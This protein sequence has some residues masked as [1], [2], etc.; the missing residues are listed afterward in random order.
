MTQALRRHPYPYRS[1]LAICSDLDETPDR[2]VYREIVLFLNSTRAT[3]MG[4]GVGLEVGNTLYFD[5]PGDQFAYW[6]TD[7]EGREMSVALMRSGHIDCFHSFGDLATTRSHA[8]RALEEL[9]RRDCQIRVWVDHGTAI[10]NFGADIM[11]GEGDVPGADVYHADLTL[12]HGVRHVWLGRVTSIVGQDVPRRWRGV[13]GTDHAVPSAVTLAKEAA[14]VALG[15]LGHS[16]FAMHWPNDLTRQITLRD[17]QSATEFIRCN[18]HWG[19]VS[20]CDTGEGIAD[21]LTDRYLDALRDGGGS[22]ILY[23]HLGKIRDSRRPF[24]PQTVAAFQRL[25]ERAGRGE[26]LVCTTARMLEYQRMKANVD[27]QVT[28][29][30]SGCRVDVHRRM[31]DLDLS[32]LTIYTPDAP[33]QVRVD[34]EAAPQF[35]VN[36][37]E[38]GRTS[39]SFA[40]KPLHLPEI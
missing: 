28:P 36:P 40:W 9:S 12:S 25:A 19:G 6:N 15:G 7:D 5:M 16:K 38:D 20:S 22:S 8:G 30:P 31:P 17:G 11:Q 32:G 33:A 37:P 27:V 26:V 39:I 29:D 21:V 18:P 1:A 3:A 23:T 14:K 35:V 34:G 10:S 4:P 2:K 13:Y 24:N